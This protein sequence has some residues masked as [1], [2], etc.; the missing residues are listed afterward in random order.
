MCSLALQQ[1]GSEHIYEVY[2]ENACMAAEAQACVHDL[3]VVLVLLSVRSYAS[4]C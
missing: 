2:I 3:K 4:C 1:D